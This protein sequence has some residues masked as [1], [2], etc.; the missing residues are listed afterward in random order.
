MPELRVSTEPGGA[1][2]EVKVWGDLCPALDVGAEA[3]AWLSQF[4]GR[5]VRLL[6]FDPHGARPSDT[7]WTEGVEALNEFS[8]GFPML[9][10]SQASLDDLNGRLETP[11]PMNRFRPNVVLNGLQAY[12]EDR[13]HDLTDGA[14]RLRIVEPCTRC[15]I[16]TTD[17]AKG[18]VAGEEPLTTLKT[19]RWSKAL[20]GVMFG[21]NVIV[22]S[23]VGE[24]LRVGQH[25][26]IEWQAAASAAR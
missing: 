5:T 22:M 4:L 19:Y 20:R 3:A 7:R 2:V 25:L 21:Q 24:Q 13:I 10:I 18:E 8:D 15:K 9:A 14:I 6:R 12:D 26:D 23:G 11:L 17:Q 1:R 16:T